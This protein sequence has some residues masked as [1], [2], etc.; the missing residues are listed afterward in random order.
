MEWSRY[1]KVIEKD[2]VVLLANINNG[3]WTK[4]SKNYLNL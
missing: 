2:K 3:A 1:C 4:L